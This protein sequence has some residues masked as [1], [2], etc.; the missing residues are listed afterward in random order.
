V[1]T[2][3]AQELGNAAYKNKNFAEAIRLYDLAS[4]KD[5][6]DMS[7]LTN[8]AAVQFEQASPPP[9]GAAT[10]L[11]TR[12]QAPG[13]RHIYSFARMTVVDGWCIW[14]AVQEL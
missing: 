4:E 8:R 9:H 7:F 14:A 1:K 5:D 12:T 11:L 2:L 13:T 10:A 6:T 3:S